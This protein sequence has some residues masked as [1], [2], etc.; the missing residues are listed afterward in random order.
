[1]KTSDVVEERATALSYSYIGMR[2]ANDDSRA[3]AESLYAPFPH[4]LQEAA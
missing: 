4:R 1:L 3:V 2:Q